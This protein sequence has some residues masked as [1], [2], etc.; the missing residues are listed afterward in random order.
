[1][2]ASDVQF[3]PLRISTNVAT[4]NIGSVLYL[5][6]LFEQ[7]NTLLIPF[8]YPDE[9]IL[10]M[11]H[12]SR[13]VGASA[14]DILTKKKAAKKTFFNQSTLVVRKR[15][16]DRPDELKEVN[17]KL[18]ANG[19]I[20]MTG[21]TGLD[22]ARVTLEWLLPILQTLKEP[23]SKEP[24]FIKTLKIQLINSDYHVNATVHR[25]NL[26]QIATQ[27]YGLFSSLEKL[28]HQGVNIKYYYNTSRTVGRPG[29]CMCEKPCPGQGEG[30]APGQCKKITVLAFQTGDIIVTGARK[31]EQLDEAYHFM[32]QIL[33]RHSREILRP[34]PS[35]ST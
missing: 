28:I 34:L 12:K 24:I 26:H 33:K 4:G 21:I 8:G 3:T 1:M 35:S 2:N 30:D 9:G 31:Y 27:Q 29:I 5:D 22:F 17:I 16:L 18:F 25:D 20:Q 15:R 10:K 23:I 13:V 19:G 6:K 32:N 7:L 14:R 11:E